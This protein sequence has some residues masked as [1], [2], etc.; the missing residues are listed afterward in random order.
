MK[1]ILGVR[2]IIG[3][4]DNQQQIFPESEDKK[5]RKRK[6]ARIDTDREK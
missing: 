3:Y 1:T 2:L 4:H 6:D 5:D